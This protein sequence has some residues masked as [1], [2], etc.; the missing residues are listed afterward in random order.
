MATLYVDLIREHERSLEHQPAEKP[1]RREIDA[2]VVCVVRALSEP[3]IDEADRL[4]TDAAMQFG[5][6]RFERCRA[7]LLALR[8]AAEQQ[9][10]A[11]T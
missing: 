3:D 7:T 11:A 2:A 4:I 9:T 5:M 10:L 6:E 8:L 1:R